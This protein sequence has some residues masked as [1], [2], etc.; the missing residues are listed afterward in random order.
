MDKEVY[1]GFYGCKNRECKYHIA[2]MTRPDLIHDY[3]NLRGSALC[4]LGGEQKNG[5]KND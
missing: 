5:N 1:C 2:Q 3:L 4:P